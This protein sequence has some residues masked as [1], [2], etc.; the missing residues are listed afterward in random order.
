MQ[1]AYGRV[2]QHL[3]GACGEDLLAWSLS[4]LSDEWV[5]LRG[6]RNRRGETDSVLIGPDGVWAVEVKCRRVLLHAVDDRWWFQK[7]STRGNVY[8][9]EW[10]VD[11]GAQVS[12]NEQ[13]S[14]TPVENSPRRADGVTGG[15]G[16]HR[17]TRSGSNEA[18]PIA[19]R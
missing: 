18:T 5:M 6:H 15:S 16:P 17:P 9:S 3:S 19:V 10:A 4:A 12:Q 13:R 11:G 2:Q 7:V 1:Q 8:E 14:P